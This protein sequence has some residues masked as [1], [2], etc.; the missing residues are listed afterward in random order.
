MAVQDRLLDLWGLLD[1]GDT[2][3]A[4]ERWLTETLDRHLYMNDDLVSRLR[5]LVELE[6]VNS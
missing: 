6:A 3:R 5:S 4:V 1:D 2:R